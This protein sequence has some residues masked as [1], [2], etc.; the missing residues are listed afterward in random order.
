[1][2]TRE[3]ASPSL[4][5]YLG[6]QGTRPFLRQLVGEDWEAGHPLSLVLLL[7]LRLEP[8]TSHFKS[9]VFSDKMRTIH[10]LQW[11]PSTSQWMVAS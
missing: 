1:M 11:C 5:V 2:P 7:S 10:L 3:S 9:P 4:T 6:A 8:W